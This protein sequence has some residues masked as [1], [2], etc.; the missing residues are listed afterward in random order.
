M[1]PPSFR[2]GPLAAPFPAVNSTCWT[3]IQVGWPLMV[4][5]RTIHR[6]KALG[7]IVQRIITSGDAGSGNTPSKPMLEFA[8]ELKSGDRTW[9]NGCALW[10]CGE[11]N[12]LYGRGDSVVPWVDDLPVDWAVVANPAHTPSRL[13]AMRGKT[14]PPVEL[15]H[16]AHNRQYPQHLEGCRWESVQCRLAR[17]RSLPGR[18][19]CWLGQRARQGPIDIRSGPTPGRRRRMRTVVWRGWP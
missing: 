10:I 3:L 11:V 8:N 14:S 7:P 18:G 16:T 17:S 12:A 4:P 2:R 5:W 1:M 15:G 19:A 9:S 6:G 13:Q